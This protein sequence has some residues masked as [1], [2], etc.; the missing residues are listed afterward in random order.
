MAN[1]L[2]LPTCAHADAAAAAQAVAAALPDAAVLNPLADA[3]RA[4]ALIAQ[5]K[6]DD[7][8]DALVGEA[9]ALGKKTTVIQGI[10]A[11][12]EN[13]FL[14][15]QNVALATSFNAKVVLVSSDE[16]GADKRIALAVQAF[17]GSSVDSAMP[18]PPK[19]AACPT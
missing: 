19:P 6:A 12:G 1:I 8:L 2:I 14:A 18:Q 16:A 15:A 17:A 5:G 11:D 4:E 13:A 3:A 9:A 10:K 7:W